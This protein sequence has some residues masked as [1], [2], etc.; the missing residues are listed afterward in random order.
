MSDTATAIVHFVH[1]AERMNS[2][3]QRSFAPPKHLAPPCTPLHHLD[4]RGLVRRP[5]PS[6]APTLCTVH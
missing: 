1:C 3:L 6:D 2:C 4:K 5:L